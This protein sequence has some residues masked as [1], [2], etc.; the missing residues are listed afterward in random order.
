MSLEDVATRDREKKKK[1]KRK[2]KLPTL[3]KACLE[4]KKKIRIEPNSSTIDDIIK[5]R[6]REGGEGGSD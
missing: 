5:D 1:K 6:G 2:K 4:K 3:G